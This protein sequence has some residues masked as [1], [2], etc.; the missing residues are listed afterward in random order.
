MT[1][2]DPSVPPP[3]MTPPAPPPAMAPAP[4][5]PAAPHPSAL[6]EVEHAMTSAEHSV[7]TAEAKAAS[8]MN[9]SGPDT[10]ILAGA[11]LLLIIGE[12]LL[13]VLLSNGTFSL[14]GILAAEV[15]FF[16]WL[17]QPATRRT[18]GFSA[19][20][21]SAIVA[22][23]VI[24]IALFVLGDFVNVLKNLSAFTGSDIT[25]IL[26]QLCRWAG[27]VLMVLGVLSA[28][29]SSPTTAAAPAA[30]RKL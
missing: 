30:T 6:A 22:A 19:G 28:W 8:A 25:F 3:A 16:T 15:L 24:A 11:A 17:A 27:A 23:A 2:P 29:S 14:E 18:G 4:A 12:L 10:L 21:A 26:G 20:T 13:G 7:I 9:L 5:A 1:G